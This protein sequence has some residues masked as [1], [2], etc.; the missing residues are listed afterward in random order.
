MSEAYCA[1][2]KMLRSAG[3]SRTIVVR[4][5]DLYAAMMISTVRS[6]SSFATP[7]SLACFASSWSLGSPSG[8]ALERT[9]GGPRSS[10]PDFVASKSLLTE[11]VEHGNATIIASN[12][13]ACAAARSVEYV[14]SLSRSW[15]HPPPSLASLSISMTLAQPKFSISAESVSAREVGPENRFRKV[16][17]LRSDSMPCSCSPPLV[18]GTELPVRGA[19]CGSWAKGAMRVF[20]P[21]EVFFVDGHGGA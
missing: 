2:P 16:R 17:F 18:A 11:K 10:L 13:P 14:A 4:R 6:R 8:C 21:W 1:V 15:L 5:G 19:H 3:F 12:W 7:S 9:G 20:E